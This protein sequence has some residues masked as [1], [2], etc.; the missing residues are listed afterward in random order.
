MVAWFLRL[1]DV[2]SWL[3]VE[4]N[5][6]AIIVDINAIALFRQAIRSSPDEMMN[7]SHESI[8]SEILVGMVVDDE[9]LHKLVSMVEKD[10]LLEELM[11]TIV[12][13]E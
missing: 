13:I 6:D 1:E 7:R 5:H 9:V 8:V 11:I 4:G 12:D 2:L 3:L 10:E